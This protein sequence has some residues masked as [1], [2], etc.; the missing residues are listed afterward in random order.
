MAAL[1]QPSGVPDPIEAPTLQWGI[2]APG[3]IA[4]TFATAVA[5]DTRSSVVAVGS[6]DGDRA[7]AFAAL[8]EV[9]T[10]YGS[11]ADLVADDRVDAVYVASPHSEH[12]THA[13]LALEAGKP[14]LVEKAFTRNLSEADEV[15]E[16]GRSRGLLVAEAMWSRYLPH[17]D[18]VRRTVDSGVLGD[19]VLVEADHGQRLWP[20][21]PRRLADPALAG[22]SLLDLGVYPLSFLDMVLGPLRDV[23]VDGTLTDLG[24]DATVQLIARTPGGVLVRACSTMAAATPCAARVVGTAGRLEL[25]GRFYAPTTVRLIASDG[26]VLDEIAPDPAGS[27]QGFA[28]QA[29]EFVRTVTAGEMESPSMP[30]EATRRVM[31]L[32]DD[33][34]ARLS[35]VYPGE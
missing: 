29:A 3:G 7:A 4:N 14:V 5:R 13:L 23:Q 8:H 25:A 21:G 17:Y 33:A 27:P 15:L 26:A 12:R 34:R 28:Y 11:Y 31:S 9:S 20:D 10:A 35:V 16:A 30:H 22:G 2:L 6:R 1:L 19:L 32:M 18:V 24:V